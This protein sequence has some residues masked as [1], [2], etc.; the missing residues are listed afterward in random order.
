MNLNHT[1]DIFSINFSGVDVTA[2]Q[3]EISDHET[4]QLE[5]DDMSK[6][7]YMRTMQDK[8]LTLHPG[9]GIQANEV[10]R[11]CFCYFRL[12]RGCVISVNIPL[13]P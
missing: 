10:R 12:N 2:N 5:Y 13:L 4:F 11:Y 7:W 3:E 1:Y 9:G 8:Y 6:R